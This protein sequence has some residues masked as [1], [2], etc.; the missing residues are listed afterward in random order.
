MGPIIES[1]PIVIISIEPL[2][3]VVD[4]GVSFSGHF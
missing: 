4:P 3:L 2:D 1:V